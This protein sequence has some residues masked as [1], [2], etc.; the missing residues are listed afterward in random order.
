MSIG[1]FQSPFPTTLL[2]KSNPRRIVKVQASTAFW[3]QYMLWHLFVPN[4]DALIL[5]FAS[6][7]LAFPW[8]DL[9]HRHS[10]YVIIHKRSLTSARDLV[11]KY[12]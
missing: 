10:F 4:P 8:L 11:D 2:L 5:S 3:A 12:P 9:H 6:A 7:G 1:T